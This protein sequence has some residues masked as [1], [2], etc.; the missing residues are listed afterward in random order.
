MFNRVR[1]GLTGI[2]N[3]IGFDYVFQ[4]QLKNYMR[5]KPKNKMIY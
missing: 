4:E 5:S 3:D 2:S 1:W